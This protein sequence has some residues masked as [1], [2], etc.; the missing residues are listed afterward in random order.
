MGNRN[1]AAKMGHTPG[2][3]TRVLVLGLMV[4]TAGL[5]VRPARAAEPGTECAENSPW[6]PEW[7]RRAG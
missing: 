1:S 4:G 7:S 6:W 3:M 5:G 2:R